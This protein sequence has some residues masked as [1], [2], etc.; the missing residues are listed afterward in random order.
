MRMLVG[1]GPLRDDL[2]F[3]AKQLATEE[4]IV[5]CG[6]QDDACAYF[7]IARLTSIGYSERSVHKS[8]FPREHI[9]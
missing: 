8:L 6:M 5:F 7:P 9:H 4:K 3:K 2:A 1:D